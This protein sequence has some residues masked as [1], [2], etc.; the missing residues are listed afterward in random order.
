MIKTLPF[1]TN[2]SPALDLR[3]RAGRPAHRPLPPRS[4]SRRGRLGA[5]AARFRALRF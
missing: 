4:R 1:D 3:R 5:G 2:A